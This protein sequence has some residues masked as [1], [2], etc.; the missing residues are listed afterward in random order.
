VANASVIKSE[1]KIDT[2]KYFA[3]ETVRPMQGQSPYIVNL[4][5]YYQDNDHG[6]M[7]SLLYNVIGK[8][9]VVVGLDNPDVYE[10]PRQ[11]IDLMI[12]KNIGEHL[13][14]KGGIQDI[15]NQKVVEKQFVEYTNTDGATVNREQSTLEYNPGSLISLGLVVSFNNK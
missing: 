10:M 2:S 3:S 7:V 15:L 13:Q 14:I 4:G 11:V 12:T 6:L 9:I 8:R 5:L 1:I